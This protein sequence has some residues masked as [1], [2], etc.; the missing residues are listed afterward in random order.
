M[1]LFKPLL[2]LNHVRSVK[3]HKAL[4]GFNPKQ[5]AQKDVSQSEIYFFL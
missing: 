2:V 5:L 4:M 3:I 1:K